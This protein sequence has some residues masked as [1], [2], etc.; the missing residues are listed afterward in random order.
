MH[1]RYKFTNARHLLGLFESLRFIALDNDNVIWCSHPYHGVYELPSKATVWWILN[2][3]GKRGLP[4]D[5][6]NFVFRIESR[7]IVATD[8]G[9]YVDTR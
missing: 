2:C 6:N 1:F 8:A 7:M 4:S 9:L 5:L 3:T